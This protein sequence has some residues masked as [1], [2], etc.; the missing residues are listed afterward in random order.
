MSASSRPPRQPKPQLIQDEL[1]EAPFRGGLSRREIDATRQV[2]RNHV[3]AAN[4]F[5]FD[6][7]DGFLTALT[8]LPGMRAED[9]LP[10]VLGPEFLE[11][12][13]GVRD[14]VLEHLQRFQ[15]HVAR[16]VGLDPD[17][18]REEVL[19]EFDFLPRGDDESE[20]QA[21]SRSAKSWSAGTALALALD[22]RRVEDIAAEERRRNWL[23][24][25]ILLG[26]ERFDDGH[27]M[28]ARE[29][30]RLMVAAAKGAHQLWKHYARRVH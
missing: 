9:W 11:L 25:F 5:E 14:E 3:S 29:R 15:A 4:G 26:R 1:G 2:W 24:P 18:H 19:P 20:E 10:I 27:I 12:E 8:L 30:R 7:L 23:S 17:A 16:R 13:A 22:P 28:S 6:R 21:E